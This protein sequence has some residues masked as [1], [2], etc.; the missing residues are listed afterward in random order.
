MSADKPVI[1]IEDDPFV[2]IVQV[3]LDPSMPAERFAAFVHFFEHDLPDFAGWCAVLR[4]KVGR[5][6]PAEVRPAVNEGEF[7]AALPGADLTI[8]ESF[9]VDRDA[10]AAGES[11]KLVQQ[12][13]TITRDIDIAACAARGI[14]VLTLRR[15]ANI[16]CAEQT[17][18]FMLA[19]AK[20][21][22]RIDGL[23]SVEQL[24]A[25]GFDPTTFDRRH[26]ANS[27][28]ARISGLKMLYGSTLGIIGFGEIGRELALRA[29]PFGMRVLYYQR[30][31]L[32]AEE[33]AQWQGEYSPLDALLAESDWV[34]VQL[35]L[36]DS[37]RGFLDSDRLARMK[38]GATLINTAR[39]E[40]VERDALLDALRSGRLGGLALDPLYEEPGRDDDELLQFDNVILTPHTAAQP[41]RN[42]LND[43]EE[44][45]LGISKALGY[46]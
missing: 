3:V 41:R 13:G 8:V 10:L 23:I 11:L 15:R 34:S 19:L 26:T 30:T 31:R 46:T 32:S 40:I 39:A 6:Y 38:R 14:P 27:G 12:Y 2:R 42:A 1:A 4:S 5:L 37:T 44:M 22:N 24:R 33:E 43:I 17:L 9:K 25:A 28:W 36:T 21:L 18:A 35:P 7:R 16:A 20:Q 45:L 29:A